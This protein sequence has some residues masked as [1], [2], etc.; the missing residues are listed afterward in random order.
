MNPVMKEAAII[1]ALPMSP[2]HHQVEIFIPTH[3]SSSLNG[4]G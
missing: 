1:I 4:S 2:S 3:M